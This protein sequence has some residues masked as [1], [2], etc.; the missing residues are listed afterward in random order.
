MR[1]TLVS[2]FD[3]A[4]RDAEEARRGHVGGVE[5][6][7]HHLAREVARRGHEVTLLCSTMGDS[8]TAW[9]DDVRVVRIRRRATVLRAPIAPLAKH[10]PPDAEVVH[11]PA[12]Y[13]FTS[14]AVLRHGTRR[15]QRVVLDFHFEPDPGTALGRVAAR[16]WRT[17]GPRAY[18]LAS[19]VLVRSLAYA[20]SAPSLRN[21]AEAR[22]RVVPNGVDTDHFSPFGPRV[23]DPQGYVLVVGRLVPY[24]GVGVLLRALAMLRDPP[25]LL[26]AGDGPLRP[27]LEI[28]A[29]RWGVDARFLGRVPDAALPALYR[30]AALTVLPSVNRQEAFGVALLE[31]I[32][33]GTPVVASNLPGVA[34]VASLGGLIAEAGNADDLAQALERA[35]IPGALPRGESLALRVQSTHAWPAIGDRLIRAYEEALVLEAAPGKRPRASGVRDAA[36]PRDHPLL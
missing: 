20:R 29:E 32:A 24:K 33:C 34:D 13:P 26:V 35:L 22:W 17:T 27:A 18:P 14:P 1:V 23:S 2:P 10:L 9:E 15:N 36:H 28:Q 11:V 25:P 6:V 31:S 19:L 4:P 12:T 7:L 5:R 30:G 16:T 8:A 21:V 3:P